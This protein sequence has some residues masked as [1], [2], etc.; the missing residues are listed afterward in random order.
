MISI[1]SLIKD[2]VHLLYPHLCCGCG[3]DLL[4]ED[5]LLCIY[6]LN[7]LPHTHF[8]KIENNGIEKNFTGR[9]NIKAAHSEFYF[10]K[11]QVIQHLIHQLKYNGNQKIGN[12]LGAIM[13]N[14]LKES[15]RFNHIDVIVP[16]PMHKK[17]EFKRGYNQ[18]NIIAEGMA[19]TMGIPVLNDSVIKCKSTDTQTKKHR[20]ERWENVEE[21]FLVAKKEA[22]LGKNILLTDDVVTTGATLESC[23]HSILSVQ[24]T[25]LSIATLAIAGS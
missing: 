22:L 19:E 12:Y 17:K 14:S 8:E 13:G 11:G 21:T 10:S 24:G 1:T 20:L 23:G 2:A 25:S 9:I 6:C 18:A 15:G 7:D 3:T 5:Q 16:L 4:P